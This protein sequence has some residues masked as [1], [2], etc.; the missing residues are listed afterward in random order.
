MA[1]ASPDRDWV[2]TFTEVFA[3]PESAVFARVLTEVLGEEYPAEVAPYSLVSRSELTRITAEVRL[4]PEDL[5][6]DVG[7]GR[8]GPGLW[9]AAATGA[10]YL[11][12][13]ITPAALA[14]VEHRAVRLGVADRVRTAQGSFEA[15][16]VADGEA[17]AVMSVDALLFAPDKAAAVQEL[18][19]VLR[20]KG[21]LA[22]TTW[23]YRR[24]PEGRPPHVSDHRPLL[25]R[26]G[27]RVVAYEETQDWERRHRE[28]DRLMRNSVED[29]DA[30][31]GQPVERVR[32]SLE[33]MAA[34]IDV[35]IRR[36]LV[37]AE[38]E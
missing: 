3:A 17:G 22:L 10:R 11:A 38:R 9:V 18:A 35:M 13:D 15:L 34:T 1:G 8:G 16:P 7:S 19:R 6:V 2:T 36:V 31:Q 26:A 4:G 37:V 27:L 24:Q 21:R 32:A 12:V 5:L 28:L 14:E 20:S 23:D 25:A 29:L 33:E 30:E